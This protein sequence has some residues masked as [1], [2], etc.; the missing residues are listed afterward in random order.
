MPGMS[1]MARVFVS[2]QSAKSAAAAKEPTATAKTAAKVAKVVDFDSGKSIAFSD[3]HVGMNG[4]NR[5]RGFN[6]AESVVRMAEMKVTILKQYEE[7][8]L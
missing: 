1:G 8:L 3:M 7:S 6:K 2:N 4:G 5:T